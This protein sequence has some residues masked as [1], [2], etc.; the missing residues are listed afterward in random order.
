[1]YEIIGK[2][3]VGG[4][5]GG[6]VGNNNVKDRSLSYGTGPMA[7]TWDP[8]KTGGSIQLTEGNS[9]CFLKEQSYL[10]RTTM[11]GQGFMSGVHYWEILTDNR[12]EN[13]LKIGVS[14]SNSFDF[15]SAFCDHSFGFAYYGILWLI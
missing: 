11:T 3:A 8:S 6:K 7:L 1:M 12:T 2:L 15:N 10:F 4:N 13:E 14:L 9:R 5:M